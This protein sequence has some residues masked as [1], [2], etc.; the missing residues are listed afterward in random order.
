M[1]DLFDPPMLPGLTATSDF[2]TK[3]SCS[4]PPQ[5]SPA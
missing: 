3:T 2:V 1:L 5:S 4:H